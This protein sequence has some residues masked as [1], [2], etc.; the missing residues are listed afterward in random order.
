[1]CNK[2]FSLVSFSNCYILLHDY[3]LAV[4][5]VIA[6][7]DSPSSDHYMASEDAS[8]YKKTNK[9]KKTTPVA[10]AVT[11]CDDSMSVTGRGIH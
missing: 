11:T 1:M 3:D 8:R 9:S 7:D 6:T 4:T 10:A 5:G 2:R